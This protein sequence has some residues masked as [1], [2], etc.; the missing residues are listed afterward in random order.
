VHLQLRF[1]NSVA[2]VRFIRLPAAGWGEAG[3]SVPEY[4]IS[5][6]TGCASP[7]PFLQLRCA[8]TL[9]SPAGCRLGGSG[10]QLTEMGRVGCGAAAQGD[11]REG[12]PVRDRPGASWGHRTSRHGYPRRTAR[13]S[14][15]HAWRSARGAPHRTAPL[16]APHPKGAAACAARTE[17]CCTDGAARTARH[18]RVEPTC[19]G[20]GS[21]ADRGPLARAM[22]TRA[23]LHGPCPRA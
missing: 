7:T 14:K 15:P 19:Q 23:C 6:C 13:Y 8:G 16:T 21:G 3:Y 2:L 17:L 22:P 5:G 4:D 18:G 12:G 11:E 20:L 10:R 1:S 9:Y